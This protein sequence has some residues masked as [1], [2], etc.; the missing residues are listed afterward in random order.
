MPAALVRQYRDEE[1]ITK[2]AA[3][4]EQ[5]NNYVDELKLRLQKQY[6]LFPGFQT[7][8]LKVVA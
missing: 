6:G 1:C 8:L 7:P 4:V 5:F 3:A 2:L